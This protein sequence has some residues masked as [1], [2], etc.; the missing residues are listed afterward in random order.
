MGFWDTVEFTHVPLGLVPEI[1]DAIDMIVTVG[2]ELGMIDTEVVKVG[3]IQHIVASPAVRIYDGIWD[4][5][6][7]DDRDQCGSGGVRYN[8]GVNL[9]TPFSFSWFANKPLP[10]SE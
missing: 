10:G 7:L 9:P 4:H 1:L 5:L 2:K 8:L 6:A 3:Y